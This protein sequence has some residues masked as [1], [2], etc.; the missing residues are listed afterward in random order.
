MGFNLTFY[1]GKR[2]VRHER[3]CRLLF[4]LIVTVTVVTAFVV[5]FRIPS[6]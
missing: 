4:Y 2:K 3:K 6:G 5:M 1:D